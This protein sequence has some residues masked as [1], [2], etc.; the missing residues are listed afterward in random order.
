MLVVATPMSR[1]EVGVPEGPSYSQVGALTS[2]L[3]R[4]T[5]TLRRMP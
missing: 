4:G 1:G 5:R 3:F 2:V